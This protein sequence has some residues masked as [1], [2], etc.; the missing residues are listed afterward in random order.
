MLPARQREVFAAV[1][2]ARDAAVALARDAWRQRRP[3]HGFELDDAARGKLNAHNLGPYIRHRTG[4][5]LSPGK[6][7]NGL[8]FNLDNLETH[9][10]RLVLPGLGY[11]VEPGAY[12]PEFGVRL[13]INV[14]VH[15]EQ[16]PTITSCVQDE[17][18]L[19]A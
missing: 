7:V 19:L 4:H 15:A 8:G 2:E 14:F 11:T 10:T 3:L 12:L 5:S 9:D 13:E 1:K 16:G 17:V 18:L 6:L